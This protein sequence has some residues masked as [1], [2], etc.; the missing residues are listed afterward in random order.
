MPRVSL[1][2]QVGLISED[3]MPGGCGQGKIGDAFKQLND[4]QHYISEVSSS[5]KKDADLSIIEIK[6]TAESDLQRSLKS[7]QIYRIGQDGL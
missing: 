6:M 2:G 7:E 5:I 3:R 4:V 1:E